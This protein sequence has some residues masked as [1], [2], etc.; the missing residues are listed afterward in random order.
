MKTTILILALVVSIVAFAQPVAAKAVCI[1]VAESDCAGYVCT[2]YNAER[3]RWEGCLVR[4][5]WGGCGIL[6]HRCIPPPTLP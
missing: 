5:P 4:D 2:Q 3:R 1:G 6:Y